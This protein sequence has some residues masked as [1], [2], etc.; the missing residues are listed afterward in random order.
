MSTHTPPGLASIFHFLG[1]YMHNILSQNN[2]TGGLLV[3][4]AYPGLSRS[5]ILKPVKRSP[6]P[7]CHPHPHD[8]ELDGPE[9][10]EISFITFVHTGQLILKKLSHLVRKGSEERQGTH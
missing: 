5:V 3:Q 10:T 2:H 7:T 6:P 8:V 9:Q 1:N 4:A